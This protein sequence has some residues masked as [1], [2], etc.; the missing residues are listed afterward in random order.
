MHNCISFF[1]IPVSSHG[2]F[3]SLRYAARN[4]FPCGDGFAA[5]VLFRVCGLNSLVL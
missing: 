3:P 2:P 1:L 4:P 5:R